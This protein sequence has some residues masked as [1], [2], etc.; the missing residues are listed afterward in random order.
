MVQI[1]I[2]LTNDAMEIVDIVKATKRFKK[3]TEA[4]EYIIKSYGEQRK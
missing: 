3:K 1:Q 2:D 4:L